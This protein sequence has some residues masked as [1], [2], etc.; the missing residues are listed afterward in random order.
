MDNEMSNIIKL[1]KNNKIESSN[2]YKNLVILWQQLSEIIYKKSR[3][4]MDIYHQYL[5]AKVSEI[6]R[7]K[8]QIYYNNYYILENK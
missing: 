4:S 8:L 7:L 3:N 5:A 1:I 6:S 2:D